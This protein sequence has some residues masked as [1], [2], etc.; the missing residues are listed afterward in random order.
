MTNWEQSGVILGFGFRLGNWD[1]EV[2]PLDEFE[3]LQEE[4]E[5]S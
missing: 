5:N 1:M 3:V 2:C 4:K